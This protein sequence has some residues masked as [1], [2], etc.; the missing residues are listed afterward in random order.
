MELSAAV[1]VTEQE[2]L[3]LK[4]LEAAATEAQQNSP[5]LVQQGAG[6]KTDA[7]ASSQIVKF[8][9][10]VEPSEGAANPTA[11]LVFKASIENVSAGAYA[12]VLS[13]SHD[14]ADAQIIAHGAIAPNTDS[15]TD[16][17]L[18]GTRWRELFV[19]D[20]TCTAAVNIGGALNHDGSTAGFYA[21]APVAQQTGVAVTDVAIHAALVNLGL[22][23]A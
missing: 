23:T 3:L 20:I 1:G 8:A 12:D 7:T 15:T 5:M 16:L 6:W 13:L 22:I 11:V 18:T 10:Q 9:Q 21:T 2:G 14:G 19:D 17:G 4:E